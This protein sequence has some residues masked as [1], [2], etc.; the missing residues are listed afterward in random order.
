MK[1]FK[2]FKNIFTKYIYPD[3][4]YF[5]LVYMLEGMGGG[6]QD[7]RDYFEF[8]TEIITLSKCVNIQWDSIPNN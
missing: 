3:I 8:E 6:A 2:N 4:P 7:Y 5:G 1:Q